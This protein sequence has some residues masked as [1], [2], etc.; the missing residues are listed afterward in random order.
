[1]VA[2]RAL[3]AGA[4]DPPRP[5]GVFTVTQTGIIT[6]VAAVRAE[7][8]ALGTI[9]RLRDPVIADDGSVLVSGQ[10]GSPGSGLIDSRADLARNNGHSSSDMSC[11]ITLLQSR[12]AVN[13]ASN[14]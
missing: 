12:V 3:I 6:E 5:S 14:H 8:P 2:F 9:S 13:R 10:Y 7:F 11:I 4:T 1:V